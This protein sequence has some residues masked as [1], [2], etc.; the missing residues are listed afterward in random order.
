MREHRCRDH[1]RVHRRVRQDVVVVACRPS[2]WVAARVAVEPLWVEV[3]DVADLYVFQ[4]E[5]RAQQVRPPVAETDH[6]DLYRGAILLTEPAPGMGRKTVEP[7]TIHW[8][9]SDP[10]S[11]AFRRTARRRSCD[12]SLRAPPAPPRHCNG[13]FRPSQ[14]SMPARSR[15]SPRTR[16]KPCTNLAYTCDLARRERLEH[17]QGNL[18]ASPRRRLR[19]LVV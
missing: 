12:A 1:H 3:A 14:E 16:Q 15:R 5:Q 19:E 17:R 13:P 2:A 8:S 4:L 7:L 9:L 10:S 18:L 11:R 6:C